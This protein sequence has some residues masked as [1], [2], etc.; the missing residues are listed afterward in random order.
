MS[1]LIP[2]SFESQSI[3]AFNI[4][5]NPWF[6]GKDVAEVLGYKDPTTALKSHCRGVQKL[7]LIVDSLGRTQEVRIINEPDTYRLITGSTLPAAERFEA[8]LF[9]EVLPSIRKTGSYALP[10]SHP[11]L[12][13]VHHLAEGMAQAF[14]DYL[15]E[16]MDDGP[17]AIDQLPPLQYAIAKVLQKRDRDRIGSKVLVDFET[18]QCMALALQGVSKT[19]LEVLEAQ[20]GQPLIADLLAEVAGANVTKPAPATSMALWE[21]PDALTARIAHYVADKPRVTTLQIIEGIGETPTKS[22]QVRVGHALR[23]L[24][25]GRKRQST[26]GDRQRYYER[27]PVRRVK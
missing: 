22:L 27:R 6:V 3:R 4:D 17:D 11:E 24:D 23:R 26:T 20:C 5:G 13:A 18:L 14:L 19:A 16:E 9:E 10:S 8:W 15:T 7:H 1:S 12:D 25:Y 21:D 2:F